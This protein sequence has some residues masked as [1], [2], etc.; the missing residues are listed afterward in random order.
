MALAAWWGGKTTEE[1]VKPCGVVCL[2]TYQ[3][4]LCSSHLNSTHHLFHEPVWPEFLCIHLED[5]SRIE[6]NMFSLSCQTYLVRFFNSF[7]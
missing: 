7:L 4:F 5:T 6:S 2:I 3:L 1:K